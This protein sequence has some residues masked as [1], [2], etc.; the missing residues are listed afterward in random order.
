MDPKKSTL[1]R[2]FE[3]ARSGTCHN[4]EAIRKRLNYEG[5]AGRLIEGP[6]LTK[7]LKALIEEARDERAGE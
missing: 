3:L 2:A 5:Y 6:V 7:Q 4:L 1:E